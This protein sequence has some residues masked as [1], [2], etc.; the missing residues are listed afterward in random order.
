MRRR[1]YL[2]ILLLT[3]LLADLLLAGNG[4][5][6]SRTGRFDF[7]ISVRFPLA[8]D[9]TEEARQIDNIIARFSEAS[10]I[11]YDATECRH[12]FG[13]ITICRN[14]QASDIAEFWI[15]PQGPDCSGQ[16]QANS[17]GLEVSIL[18]MRVV[19]MTVMR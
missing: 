7:I 18:E 16:S 17:E 3:T 13:K 8:L 10:R 6:D 5:Y 1:D 11:L 2:V 12:Q 15:E 4:R 9:A 14:S 19:E